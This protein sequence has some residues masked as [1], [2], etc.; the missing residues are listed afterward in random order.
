MEETPGEVTILLRRLA[1]GQ[2]EAADQLVALVYREL[3]RIAGA[4]MRDERPGHT[5]QPT[6]LVN[7]AWLRLVGQ[8]RVN[9]RDRAHFFGL[10]ARMMRRVLVDHARAHLT[11]KRGAGAQ[12]L[13]LDW[14]EIEASPLKLEEVLAVHEALSRLSRFD[15]QQERIV[16]MHYFAGMTVNETAEALGVSPR[17][18]D[19]EWAVANAWLRKELSGKGAA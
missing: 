8:T 9:W 1:Q 6:A 7:E 11:S 16:E 18:V 4:Y 19:R 15:P 14:V 2:P 12:V 17:T 10:A 13:D 3:R 5:L